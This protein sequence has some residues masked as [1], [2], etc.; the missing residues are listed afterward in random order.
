MLNGCAP[1]S[2]SFQPLVTPNPAMVAATPTTAPAEPVATEPAAA[3]S[4]ITT[5][6]AEVLAPTLNMRGG[7]GTNYPIVSTTQAG[8]Q[9]EVI[10]QV[11]ACR[12]L[13]VRANDGE[14][15]ISGGAQFTRLDGEC[16]TVAEAPMPAA[17]APPPTATAVPTAAAPAAPQPT[18]PPAA[19]PAAPQPTAPAAEEPASAEDALPIGQGC[20]LF[21][22][23]LGPE[24]T[25]TLTRRADG[26]ADT[27]KLQPNEERPYCL[28]PGRYDYTLDA[29]PPWGTLNDTIEVTAGD[30]FYFPIRP[31]E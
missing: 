29:P 23:Q 17:P 5:P 25:I 24:I 26:W 1:L 15:W 13:L 18:P 27:F 19:E 20:Y 14:A 21:Q 11:D 10:G 3:E 16:A 8:E 4:T 12:W 22:N 7:P 31:K 9:F 2:P 28:D 30:R 6:R